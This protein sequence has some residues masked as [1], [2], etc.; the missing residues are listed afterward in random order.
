MEQ[1]ELTAWLRLAL[2]PGIGN[3][4]ARRLLAAFGLPQAVFAQ[5]AAALRPLLTPAQASALAEPPEGLDALVQTTAAW[6]AAA[7]PGQGRALVTLGDARYPAALL[8][9]E[10]P[11]LMLYLLGQVGLLDSASNKPPAPASQ[12]PEAIETGANGW[13]DRALAM[14]GSRN[15]TPQGAQNARQ[16]ARALAGAGLTVVSGLALGVDG[17]AHEGALA[18]CD[19]AA[20]AAR[21]ATL[22]VVGTGLDRV[23]PRQHRALAHRIAAQG[24]LVSEYPL[25]TPPLPANFPKRNRLIAGLARGTLVVEAALQS[26]SLI[27]ARLAAEQGKEVFAIPGSIHSPQSRGCHA[28]IRQGAK[29]VE[30]AEDVLEEL[31]WPQVASNS[32][33]AGAGQ[34][35]AGGQNDDESTLLEALG[36]DPVGLDALLARTGLDTA[37]LQARLLTLELDGRVGRLPGGLFQRLG[38]A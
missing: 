4:T 24:L 17:A 37:T 10:D 15:P 14:V 6:L 3:D 8:A 34:E 25:G 12:A 13:P 11:P 5:S 22:A 29:L 18:A 31:R 2:T 32:I 16:F 23:Y 9:T 36:A 19:E 21:L 28:L 26:G 1:E 7:E 35:S 20:P 27:T 38:Q 33:A 30:T